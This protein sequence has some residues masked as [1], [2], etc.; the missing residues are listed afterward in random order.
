M[1]EL[2]LVTRIKCLYKGIN[3]IFFH[4]DGR[5]FL[6]SMIKE[7]ADR[8]PQ[9]LLTRVWHEPTTFREEYERLGQAGFLRQ[10]GML[11]IIGYNPLE[12]SID[13]LDKAVLVALKTDAAQVLHRSRKYEGIL[14]L[15]KDWV[16]RLKYLGVAEG[17][18]DTVTFE[19][20]N[21]ARCYNAAAKLAKKKGYDIFTEEATAIS[22]SKKSFTFSFY[23]I[24][25]QILTWA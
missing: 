21:S 3:G 24:N 17:P 2:D 25:P 1:E 20:K 15:N 5:R 12:E 13:L 14:D 7:Q 22:G 16:R 11:A 10:E 23:K 19:R 4:G 9:N 18:L 6:K 8:Y